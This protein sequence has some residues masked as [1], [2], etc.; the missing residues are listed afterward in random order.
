MALLL[1]SVGLLMLSSVRLA[2]LLRRKGVWHVGNGC[3]SLVRGY[4]SWS[5]R[6][7]L[8]RGKMEVM[9]GCVGKS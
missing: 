8:Q 5:M 2:S 9:A 3:Q 6:A 7:G 1:L 4:L